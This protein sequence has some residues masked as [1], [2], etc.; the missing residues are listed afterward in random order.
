[1]QQ[2]YQ[3]LLDGNQHA[4]DDIS[5]AL[6]SRI[7]EW[8]H[9]DA[10]LRLQWK[11]DPEKSVRVEEPWA[12]ILAGEGGFEGELAR[13]GYRRQDRLAEGRARPAPLSGRVRGIGRET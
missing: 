11:Q 5:S 10:R 1:M 6:Q 12:H 3:E 4:L 2:Q 7:A 9:P 8:A 13:F